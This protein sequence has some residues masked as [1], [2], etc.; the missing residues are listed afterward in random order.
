[1]GRVDPALAHTVV[2]AATLDPESRAWVESLGLPPG[3]RDEAVARLHAHLLRVAW[4]EVNRRRAAFGNA[5]PG[6]AGDLAMQAADDAL[7]AILRKLPSYRGDSR[8]TTWTAKFAILEA[9]VKMRRRAWQHREVT[10]DPEAWQRFAAATAP[11]AV[12]HGELVQ[13]IA[14]GIRTALS[15]HQREILVAVTL[16]DVPIDV[17]A[18][19]L[20]TTRGAIYKTL[21]DARRNLRAHLSQGE[22][23]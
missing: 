14:E 17:L 11:D 5:S 3:D 20:Q 15:T 23:P 18:D 10:L 4:F 8:F 16:D 9:S 2:G 19:R 12:E 7:M 1:V 13:A 22:I 6:E 21:H